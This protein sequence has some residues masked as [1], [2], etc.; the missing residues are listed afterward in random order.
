MTPPRPSVFIENIFPV[1]LLNLQVYFEN[2]GNPF[3]GLHRWYSRKPL[4]FSRASVLGSLLPAD[5]T[6]EEFEYLLGLDR[7]RSLESDLERDDRH[8]RTRLYKMPPSPERVRRVQEL[9]EQVWGDKTPAVLDAFAGGGSIP[10]EAARYGLRVFASDL[11]PVAVVTMKAAIEFPLR[12]GA[13]LQQDID[14]WV[15]WVGEQAEERLKA[16]FPAQ[17]GET[18]QNY[19]W[20]HTVQCP[21]CQS[22]VPLSP[23]WWLSKTSNYAGKGQERKVTSDWYAVKPVPNPAEKR[24]DFEL[25]KGKKG[26]GNTI[27]TIDGDF[28]PNDFATIGR[29]VGKCPNCS[30]IIEDRVIKNQAQ[31]GGL[32]HQIYAV[33][34]KQGK[35]SLEFRTPNKIDL[36]GVDQAIA[37]LKQRL[38]YHDL[39]DLVPEIEIPKG[40]E[41]ERLSKIGIETWDQLFNPR[42][43]LTLVTYVE[44]INEAK[45]KIR[46]ELG[47]EKAGAIV[48]YLVMVLDRCVDRQCRLARWHP[49][50]STVEG[51]SAQHALNLMW[52]YPE[53]SGDG[54]LWHS[55]ADVFASDYEKLCD[56]LGTKINSSSLQ[57]QNLE[58]QSKNLVAPKNE[59]LTAQIQAMAVARNLP[60]DPRFLPYNHKLVDRA[61]ELRKNM[62]PAEKKLWHEFLKT[63]SDRVWRQRPIDHFIVDFYCPKRH[64]VIEVDGDSHFTE[65]GQASDIERTQILE[66]YGLQVLRFTNE[67]VLQNFEGVCAAI[68]ALNPPSPPWEGGSKSN[69]LKSPLGSGEQEQSLQVPLEKG[70]LGGFQ[71]THASADSL[72]HL[73]DQSIDA[74]V[75]DPPYYSTIQYAE[76]SDFFYCLSQE[77]LIITKRGYIP[78]CDVT[79]NDFVL[80][81]NGKWTAIQKVGFRNYNDHI[82][83][84]QTAYNGQKLV[85][86]PG[87]KVWTL[88]KEKAGELTGEWIDSSQLAKGDYVFL[89][90]LKTVNEQKSYILNLND[91]IDYF[92]DEDWL[93]Y[94]KKSQEII[95]IQK[96][97]KKL[98]TEYKTLKEIAAK[99]NVNYQRVVRINGE[100]KY[101]HFRIKNK[102]EIDYDLM[103]VFGYFLAEGSILKR[104]SKRQ[105][106]RLSFVF[107]EKEESYVNEI[108]KTVWEKFHCQGYIQRRDKEKAIILNFYCE[109]LAEFFSKILG[110]NSTE[111]KLADWILELPQE[112][113]SGLLTGYW[114]G[115]GSKGK[116]FFQVTTISK[117]L[118]CQIRLIL[119]Q[120]GIVSHLYFDKKIRTALFKDREVVSKPRFLIKVWGKYREKLANILN[121]E[122]PQVKQGNYLN[123]WTSEGQWLPIRNIKTSF[124]TGKVYNLTTESHNYVTAQ[125]C[126]HNCW[127]K[128]I[129]GDIFPELYY[130]E[131]T[132]K[133][134]E[135]VANPSRF[136]NM[137]ASPKTLADQDY[138]AKM[139]MA[140]SEYYR[141]LKDNGVMTVQFNH[142]DSGAWDVLAQS[143]ITAGFEITASWAVSTENPQNLHQAQKNSVSSTVLLVCRKRDPNAGTAWWDDI[144]PELTN[145]V[146]ERAPEFE[147]NDITGIDLY[148]SAF[149]PALNVFSR[150]WPVLDSSG[151]EMRP[152]VAFEEA[153]KAISHYRLNKLLNQDTSGFDA[154]TQWYILA[155]D[156]F[157]AREFPFDDAL[158]LALAV[159]GFDLNAD[160]KNAHKLIE[161]K[162][163][164]CTL[165]NPQQRLKKRAFS[166]SP[167]DFTFTS[168]IDALHAVIAIY[169]EE[170]TIESVRQFLKKTELLTND[171]FMKAW[172]VALKAIPHIGDEKKR[173]PEEKVLA[174]LWLAM[175][176]IQAKVRYVTPEDE[177]GSGQI[178]QTKLF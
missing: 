88:K 28:D 104:R 109:P 74:V 141:V 138:E 18:I 168:A 80:D 114:N 90:T 11:N 161:A 159:G 93:Y 165:L 164:N 126:V 13:E 174:D 62:T 16:F 27:K 169:Q 8:N 139:Q 69:L 50:R 118:A 20:A 154:L 51:C 105:E 107:H 54:E 26:K 14:Q 19:L 60:Y 134:R 122:T 55:C 160:L 36:D 178:M 65:E 15:Q 12:F 97:I 81:L 172:E 79:T 157:Q 156:T 21:H 43:L 171:Q 167:T 142:K 42:Q 149:G 95:T 133:D 47:E 3:K 30:E 96:A 44:I 137:G 5:V 91:Y 144:R 1:N 84:I 145:L 59:A 45:E 46:A 24:V 86:T 170:E 33:A 25:I 135:A 85:I 32:G 63:F 73:A 64:L 147:A 83:E 34:F 177:E 125:C 78:I 38:S 106:G 129:L 127:Q 116:E 94:G 132:D 143:L 48:T 66:A 7:P 31:N 92:V 103:K 35:G 10:F 176:E 111:K 82:F 2:G 39:G 112:L 110:E 89:P 148:L 140:F 163:G 146:E 100:E 76:L 77:T 173:I 115:D 87:H 162:S 128:R 158:Q 131:L 58:P 4:S 101:D 120:Q 52:N 119:Q 40:E 56:L 67:E 70:D 166:I 102:I 113:L 136:R 99:L 22:T 98:G 37:Y 117:N 130:T 124:Y 71:I 151:E 150:A 23:N 175:D 72:Y 53:T 41:T 9:C 57:L 155:W 68:E 29:G 152:E 75:T 6:M 153:R 123:L 49:S 108:L 121:V 17:E 61:K